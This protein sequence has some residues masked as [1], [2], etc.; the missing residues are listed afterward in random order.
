MKTEPPHRRATVQGIGKPPCGVKP[1][2]A[3]T[4]FAKNMGQGL[5]NVPIEHHPTFG[6]IISNRYMKVTFKIPKKGHLPTPVGCRRKK[7][8]K[9]FYSVPTHTLFSQVR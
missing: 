3:N 6:D 7:Q 1:G 9:M 8:E 5:L 2:V 4:T